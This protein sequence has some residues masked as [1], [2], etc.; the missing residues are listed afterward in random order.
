VKDLAAGLVIILLVVG[1]CF[2]LSTM[3]PE[4]PATPSQPFS[5]TTGAPAPVGNG[6]IVMRVNGEP[7]TE[8]EFDAIVRGTP[9]QMR[10]YYMTE[11]GRRALAE[12]IVKLKAL[13]QEA[14]RLGVDKDQEVNSQL[15]LDR[16]NV[17]ATYA[18]RKLVKPATEA[19]LRNAYDTNKQAFAVSSLSHILIAYK[20]G[21]VPPKRG[22]EAPSASEA[23]AKANRLVAS[24]RRG[25]NF[26]A[27]AAVESDDSESGQ[28][29]GDLGVVTPD[30]LPPEIGQVV[31]RLKPG[32]VSDP[33]QTRF[34]VQIF[35][36]SDRRPVDYSRVKNSLEQKVQQDKV[37]AAVDRLQHSA[38]VE[39]DPAFFGSGK[40]PA[41]IRKK[42]S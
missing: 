30:Q 10:T 17:M 42:A 24:I 37:K 16:A 36:I 27:T 41:P 25:Q 15:T 18:L 38:K 9:E 2:G 40:E 3:R 39:L 1:V 21:E 5:M 26:G 34:G 22:G 20:G 29:G 14:H 23:M 12:E 4:L 33:V 32:E 11:G 19:E 13:E 6:K 7:V 31:S 8:Y 28:R 35:Q